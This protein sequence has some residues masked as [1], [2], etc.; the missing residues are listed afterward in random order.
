MNSK[1]LGLRQIQGRLL[2]AITLLSALPVAAQDEAFLRRVLT[3]L[4]EC[5]G[6]LDEWFGRPLSIAEKLMLNGKVTPE[7]MDPT[8]IRQLLEG[9]CAMQSCRRFTKSE[10][11]RR[12]ISA[13]FSEM[14]YDESVLFIPILRDPSPHSISVPDISS[15]YSQRLNLRVSGTLSEIAQGLLPESDYGR[16]RVLVNK[17]HV[18]QDDKDLVPKLLLVCELMLELEADELITFR[19]IIDAEL[20]EGE[21]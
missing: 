12:G 16:V 14:S 2:N 4:R 7:M 17:G 5:E 6:D 15:Q 11:K 10:A 8:L 19:P 18:S 20:V 9:I 21:E 3:S 13:G 1:A